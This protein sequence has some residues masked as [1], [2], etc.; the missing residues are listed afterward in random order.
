MLGVLIVVLRRNSVASARG[1]ARQPEIF[2]VNLECVPTDPH[3]R[4]IA[5][6]RLL[7]IWSPAPATIATARA[8]RA[9]AWFHVS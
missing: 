5:I 7:T 3:T 9:L 2:F 8:F 6:E 1:V 4:P